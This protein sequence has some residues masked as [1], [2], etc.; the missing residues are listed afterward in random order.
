MKNRRFAALLKPHRIIR[1]AKTNI[2]MFCLDV[3]PGLP[4]G[5]TIA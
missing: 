4:D 3:S 1:E 5:V 2:Q